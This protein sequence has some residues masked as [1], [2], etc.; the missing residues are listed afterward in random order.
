[1]SKVIKK[2]EIVSLREYI[3]L[4]IKNVEDATEFARLAM[5]KAVE[6]ASN[7][8]EKRLDSMNEFREAL[9]DQ[10]AKFIT[11]DQHNT[12]I[13]ALDDKYTELKDKINISVTK[14]QHDIV[15][16]QVKTNVNTLHDFQIRQETK[17]S[18]GSVLFVGAL[19][20]VGIAISVL[21]LMKDIKP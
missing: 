7:S 19:S 9:K 6:L 10:S 14:E 2:R 21:S 17:A 1:M 15:I 20:I 4:R 8:M 3:D 12:L 11:I 16:D 5:E 13:K 18:M